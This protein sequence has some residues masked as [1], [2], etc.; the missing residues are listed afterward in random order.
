MLEN[1]FTLLEQHLD[2][3]SLYLGLLL[4][5]VVFLESLLMFGYFVPAAAILVFTGGLVALDTV[6]FWP[7]MIGG[8]AGALAGSTL[9]FWL[10]RHHGER[11]WRIW[12][13]DRYPRVVSRGRRLF[14][15]HGSASLVLGRFSKPLRPMVA[16][17]AG[18]GAMPTRRFM[19]LNSMAVLLWSGTCLGM[20][21]GVGLWFEA[22]SGRGLLAAA[23]LALI[24][25]WWWWLR[26]R[27]SAA[28]A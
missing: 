15:R 25:L 26:R 22:V 19:W 18:A 3:R 13:L 5:L 27:L 28:S 12:P 14:E 16:A 20:G 1:L 24:V 23:V 11:L 17:M 21:M 9:T 7:A 6:S 2:G 4:F 8:T 10:G